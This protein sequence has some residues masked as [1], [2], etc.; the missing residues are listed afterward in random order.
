MSGY[1]SLTLATWNANSIK[2][3]KH[4]LNDF[5]NNHDIDII[6]LTET[7]LKPHVSC[8]L[9]NY[10]FHRFDRDGQSGGG[11]GII[12]K[13]SINHSLLP[14]LNLKAIETIAIS[15]K[16][17]NGTNLTIRCVYCPHPNSND[18]RNDLVK[19]TGNRAPYINGGDYNCLHQNWNCL[20]S[21]RGGRTLYNYLNTS[22][23][24]SII[25]P[26]DYTFTRPNRS[27]SVLDLYLTNQPQHVVDIRTIHELSSDHFPVICKL[28]F[29]INHIPSTR[30]IHNF[31]QADWLLYQSQIDESIL[32]MNY[33]QPLQSTDE[34]DEALN[35]LNEIIYRARD[36]AVP[37]TPITSYNKVILTQD[38]LDTISLRNT[39][40][41]I[42]LRTRCPRVKQLVNY[43]NKI[44]KKK[45]LK[46]ANDSWQSELVSLEK[47]SKKFWRT[48]KFVKNKRKP[49]PPFK[50]V[51]DPSQPKLILNTEKSNALAD[52][53]DL[54]HRAA[55]QKSSSFDGMISNTNS[56]INAIDPSTYRDTIDNV[57]TD[58]IK[59][60]AKFLK[61]FKAAGED[62]I[63]NIL[64]KK[65]PDNGF[66]FLETIFKSCFLLG[67]FP[68]SWKIA[69]IVPVL[70]PGKDPTI[71]SSYRPISLLSSI[72]KLL[73]RIIH[74]RL[75]H[76]IEENNIFINE[77]F[78]F[79]FGHST[80][81][82]V[83]R[84]TNYIISNRNNKLST[85]MA[86]LDLQRAFDSV[87]QEAL[88]SKIN[89]YDFPT[90][91]VKMVCS[92]LNNR[93]FFVQI[94]G[95]KSNVHNILAGVPQG[96]VLAPMLFNLFINDIPRSPK[97]MLALF[98]DDTAIFTADALAEDIID[99]LN[100]YLHV[101]LKYF[102]DW[103]LQVNPSK[104]EAIYFTRC[105][106]IIKTPQRP[107]ELDG[108]SL[109][110][111]PVVRYLGIF[112]DPRLTY[113]NHLRYIIDKCENLL[114][115]LYPL[116]N[117]KSEFNYD[118]KLLLYKTMVL[119]VIM[120]G[121]P[122]WMNAKITNRKNI[123]ILQNK[124]LKLIKNVPIR[125][126]T[127]RLHNETKIKKIDDHAETLKLNYISKLA[128]IENDLINIL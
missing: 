51:L 87:W 74:K 31:K 56:I 46:I 67:Y 25:A 108:V 15:V 45:I 94:L 18:F 2:Y 28:D 98:A 48:S 78:G 38:I 66:K 100:E 105:R 36:A 114:K 90:Y 68:N 52:E 17:I 37:M 9:P 11:V 16:N 106:S 80:V 30:Q 97:C 13:N 84:I 72:S 65:L 57:S 91:L 43:L 44:I 55:Q 39:E 92:F 119:N 104:C 128:L 71:P 47:G 20:R 53:F 21:N 8:S 123:Q 75:S 117:K 103:K 79:R 7:H 40:R 54:V 88:I 85:G 86:L 116:L 127:E 69:K 49:I 89:N 5:L 6:L 99:N 35:S 27:P 121:S 61:P 120:Y 109:D 83:H 42:W 24:C 70:K 95:S 81:H 118:N 124:F 1:K 12:I 32:N 58:E 50:N 33:D 19:L 4:E 62:G 64:I 110:W 93:K 59:N 22:N 115:S 101:I 29:N 63:L 125:Y 23:N 122:I 112:L 60:F 82:Q 41:R 10:K 14:D 34:I 76:F 113:R 126:R 77:Q 102:A 73:E 96:S 111:K 26:D 107:L 3:K